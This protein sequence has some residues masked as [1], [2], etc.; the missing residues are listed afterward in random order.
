L[1]NIYSK[2]KD[3]VLNMLNI[4]ADPI[5]TEIKNRLTDRVKTELTE[6]SRAIL[7]NLIAG[8]G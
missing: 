4:I 1:K 3:V 2:T 5:K 6:R 7:S 8:S